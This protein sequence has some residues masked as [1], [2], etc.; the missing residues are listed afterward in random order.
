MLCSEFAQKLSKLSERIGT[1]DDTLKATMDTKA[2]PGLSE[3]E[4]RVR[5]LESRPSMDPAPNPPLPHENPTGDVIP[6]A[7]PHNNHLA[8]CPRMDTI[9]SPGVCVEPDGLSI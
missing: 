1:T 7:R 4:A 9:F 3:L 6:P 2:V 8:A 5:I